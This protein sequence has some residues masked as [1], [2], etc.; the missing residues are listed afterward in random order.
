MKWSSCDPQVIWG[1]PWACRLPYTILCPSQ[2]Q[3]AED[4]KA[5]GPV[6][7]ELVGSKQ[8]V[9][10]TE[11]PFF[12]NYVLAAPVPQL[13]Q[14]EQEEQLEQAGRA[15]LAELLPGFLVALWVL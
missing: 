15:E 11:R 7:R 12:H 5:Q 4:Q 2:D 9:E 14:L 13:V 3:V 6:G 10:A 1:A 8:L